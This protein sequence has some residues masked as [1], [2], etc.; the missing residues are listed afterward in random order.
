MEQRGRPGVVEVLAV[1]V[2]RPGVEQPL[3]L[4]DS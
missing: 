4:V 1:A 3:G 2:M